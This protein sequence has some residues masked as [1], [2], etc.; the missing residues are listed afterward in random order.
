MSQVGAEA[1]TYVTSTGLPMIDHPRLLDSA[2]A[3]APLVVNW[4]KAWTGIGLLTF[5]RPRVWLF[6][7]PTNDGPP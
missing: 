3:Y 4:P 7:G 1:H 6:T 5:D 2:A